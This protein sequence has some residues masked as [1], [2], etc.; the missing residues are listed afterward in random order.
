MSGGANVLVGSQQ[1]DL[2][3]GEDDADFADVLDGEF[4]FAVG[5]GDAADGAGKV[6]AFQ[7][8]DVRHFEGF[9]EKVVETNQSQ[10]VGNV[11]AEDECAHEVRSL[12][13]GTWRTGSGRRG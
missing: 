9:E 1:M 7:R 13:D 12:L 2:G 6:V 10:S 8:L 11:E 5:S 3:V 4:C